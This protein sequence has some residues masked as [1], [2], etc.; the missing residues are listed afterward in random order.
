MDIYN[1]LT[2]ELHGEKPEPELYEINKLG[3]KGWEL[4]DVTRHCQDNKDVY[5]YRKKKRLAFIL[6]LLQ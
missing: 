6:K 3:L 4:V 2:I 5:S 1:R